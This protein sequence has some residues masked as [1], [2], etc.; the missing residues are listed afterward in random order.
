[1]LSSKKALPKTNLMIDRNQISITRAGC[2]VEDKC[3]VAPVCSSS[4]NQKDLPIRKNICLDKGT[5]IWC[6]TYDC[7]TNIFLIQS[8]FVTLLNYLPDGSE[9]IVGVL[10]SGQALGLTDLFSEF[11][12]SFVARSLTDVKMCKVPIQVVEALIKDDLE[13][14][15]RVI[16]ILSSS[17]QDAMEQ[18]SYRDTFNARDR[19]LICLRRL[20]EKYDN[21]KENVT[22]SITHEEIAQLVGTNRI[23][24]TRA[25]NE[26]AKAG[27]IGLGR[28]S[29]IV[30][31]SEKVKPRNKIDHL[32][33]LMSRSCPEYLDSKV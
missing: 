4:V 11:D 27:Y 15:I 9:S 20:V 8:G 18:L 29:I 1:M 25:L 31:P 17:Y 7:S 3:I 12:R 16:N 32:T 13:V 19:I 14:A 5:L 21:S 6:E 10:T 30:Y 22:L 33:R 26:L 28:S 23:T 24:A 2:S